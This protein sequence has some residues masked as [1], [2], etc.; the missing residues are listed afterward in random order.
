[1]AGLWRPTALKF[2]CFGLLHC[3]IEACRLFK[4]SFCQNHECAYRCCFGQPKAGGENQ[5]QDHVEVSRR[6]NHHFDPPKAQHL[7]YLA[8]RSY[9]TVAWG[10]KGKVQTYSQSPNGSISVLCCGHKGGPKAKN[11]LYMGT[12]NPH[13]LHFARGLGDLLKSRVEMCNPPWG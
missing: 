6:K 8:D 10:L 4:R 9:S 12:S 11:F 3:W 7:S 13:S 5:W 1:M 2:D